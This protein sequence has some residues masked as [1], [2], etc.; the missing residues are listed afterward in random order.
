MSRGYKLSAVIYNPCFVFIIFK[1]LTKLSIFVIRTRFPAVIYS[2]PWGRQAVCSLA[3]DMQ[4]YIEQF[5]IPPKQKNYLMAEC[6]IPT[7]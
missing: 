2:Y 5:N 6:E 4:L 3:Q 1:K 7:N